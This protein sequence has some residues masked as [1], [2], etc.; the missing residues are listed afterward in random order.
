MRIVGYVLRVVGSG[1]RVAGKKEHRAWGIVGH[2]AWR[3]RLKTQW[4]SEDKEN[5]E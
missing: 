5:D 2:S 1:L 4:A 3:E